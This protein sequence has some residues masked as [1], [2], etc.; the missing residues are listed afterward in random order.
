LKH[1]PKSQLIRRVSYIE[2]SLCQ[3]PR[4]PKDVRLQFGVASRAYCCEASLA[5]SNVSRNHKV[6]VQT[7]GTIHGP[8]DSPMSAQTTT[9]VRQ[10]ARTVVKRFVHLGY[11]V[12]AGMGRCA[13]AMASA[14]TTWP[15]AIVVLVCLTRPSTLLARYRGSFYLRPKVSFACSRVCKRFTA[16]E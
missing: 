12:D 8:T 5:M 2:H 10:A 15:C 14:C 9:P 7:S 13:A 6:H 16:L 4:D 11:V 3:G 1:E